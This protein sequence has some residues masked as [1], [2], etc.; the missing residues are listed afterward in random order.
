[1]AVNITNFGVISY[2]DNHREYNI[3]TSGNNIA[4]IIRQCEAEDVQAEECT[5]AKNATVHS[6]P[7]PFFV[8]EKL[9]ELGLYTVEQFEEMYHA[10]AKAD[11]KTLVAFLNRYHDLNVLNWGTYNKKEVYV[12]LKNYFG[13][14]I[15]YGSRNFTTYF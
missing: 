11:A 7:L 3:H 13:D 2:K 15:R 12:V 1:M 9:E 14:E 8:P 10:A 6:Q 4:D 5:D